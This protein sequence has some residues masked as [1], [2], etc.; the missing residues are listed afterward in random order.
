MQFDTTARHSTS[1][2]SHACFNIAALRYLRCSPRL[3]SYFLPPAQPSPTQSASQP[4]SQPERGVPC[5]GSLF[6]FTLLC[7][8][9]CP[10]LLA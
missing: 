10:A 3:H 9:P 2:T 7:F 6:K 8:F 1:Q 4:A 5:W